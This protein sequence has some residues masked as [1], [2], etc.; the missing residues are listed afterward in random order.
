[1]QKI[2]DAIS[3]SNKSIQKCLEHYDFAAMFDW[4]TS[5]GYK[6]ILNYDGLRK[7]YEKDY[8]ES[9]KDSELFGRTKDE[10]VTESIQ[11][12]GKAY[13]TTRLVTDWCKYKRVYSVDK[14]WYDDF[15]DTEKIKL[16]FS[17]FERLPYTNFYIDLTN[18]KYYA[19]LYQNNEAVLFHIFL[20]N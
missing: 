14:D 15:K 16:D 9:I 2:I 13:A 12:T 6:N 1:M 7:Y 10:Y 4:S 17:M 11:E 18:Q 20:L 3:I 5:V 8:D 19:W